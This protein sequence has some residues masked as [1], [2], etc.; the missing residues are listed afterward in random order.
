MHYYLTIEK[1]HTALYLDFQRNSHYLL[2]LA[3]QNPYLKIFQLQHLQD[4]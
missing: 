3:I 2:L 1:L 4:Y